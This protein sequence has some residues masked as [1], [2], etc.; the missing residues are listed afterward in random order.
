MR[1]RM[2]RALMR[3]LIRL[4]R[5]WEPSCLRPDW[6]RRRPG[7]LEERHGRPRH[8]VKVDF[9][10]ENSPFAGTA[11]ACARPHGAT[12]PICWAPISGPPTSEL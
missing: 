12:A 3:D 4:G 11:G 7:R 10:G 6:V 9:D 1:K 8:F 5:S 2:I